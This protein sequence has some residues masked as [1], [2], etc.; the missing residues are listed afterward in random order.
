MY[1]MHLSKT[2]RCIKNGV[3]QELMDL[4]ASRLKGKEYGYLKIIIQDAHV[5]AIEENER[6]HLT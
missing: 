4:I 1:H 6:K 3:S 5:F 2:Q